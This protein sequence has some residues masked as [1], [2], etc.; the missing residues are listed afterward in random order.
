MLDIAQVEKVFAVQ[1]F[2]IDHE[3][4]QVILAVSTIEHYLVFGGI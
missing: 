1:R 4:S 3:T 2:Y